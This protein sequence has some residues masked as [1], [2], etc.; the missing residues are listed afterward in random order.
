MV[1]L[2]TRLTKILIWQKFLKHEGP[3][4]TDVFEIHVHFRS[5]RPEV[6]CKKSVLRNFTKLRG[7]H[8]CQSLFFNKVAASDL[9]P[10]FELQVTKL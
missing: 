3:T 4:L 7:K 10:V 6:F 2:Q 9:R 5:T 1:F 8:L